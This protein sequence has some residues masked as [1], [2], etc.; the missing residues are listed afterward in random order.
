MSAAAH[1]ETIPLVGEITCSFT[2]YLMVGDDGQKVVED[3]VTVS[4]AAMPK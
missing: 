4:L 2:S 1:R 3:S